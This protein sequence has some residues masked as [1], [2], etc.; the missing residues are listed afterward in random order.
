METRF[1]RREWLLAAGSAALL[2]GMAAADAEKPGAG[3]SLRGAFMILSTP[4]TSS[5]AV[6]YDDLA[7]EVDFL[8]RCGVQGLVW[9]QN[10]SE[11]SKLTKDER[12]RGMDV[13]ARAARGKTPAL[14]LGVQG[15]DTAEMLDY[16]RH[17][18]TLAPDA[19][20]AI[21]PTTASSLDDYRKYYRALCKAAKRPVVR[22]LFEEHPT[23]EREAVTIEPVGRP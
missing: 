15:H 21:P 7:G 5:K 22:Y 6:S 3:K 18:E 14:V 1:S 12:I 13:I 17:A 19:V 23:T 20:I 8:V 9:P 2:P 11:Q 16:A 4:Y 10:A